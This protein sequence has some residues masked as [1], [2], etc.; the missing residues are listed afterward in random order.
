MILTLLRL[1]PRPAAR[2]LVG[3]LAWTTAAAICQGVALG[4]VG[5]VVAAC[6]GAPL[7]PIPAMIALAVSIAVYLVV[8]WAAQMT[9]FRVGS[10]TARALHLRL[11][12]TLLDV[13]L[14]WFTPTR[15][16]GVIALATDGV[17]QLMSLPAIL[18]RPA[19][20]AIVTPAAAAVTLAVID[21]RATLAVLAMILV[22]WAASRL[23]ARLGQRVDARRH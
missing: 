1:L 15:A 9:A 17:V 22:C 2:G 23:S 6:L 12:D 16:A 14:G 19:L 20:T 10:L 8:Q 5:A 13:P 18:L 4:L 3:L 11:G 7:D 21:V